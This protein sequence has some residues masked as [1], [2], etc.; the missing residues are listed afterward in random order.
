LKELRKA[1]LE[2]SAGFS[3]VK[4]V[5]VTTDAE[6]L[7]LYCAR[8]S[9]NQENTDT[10]LLRYLIR[11]KHWSPFELAHMV[12]EIRTS[13]AIAQQILRHRSFSFQEFSQR[14]AEAPGPIVYLGR[15]KG[16]TNRQ[17]SVDDLTDDEQTRWI[18]L[19]MDAYKAAAAAYKAALE[20]GIAN[21]C[22]RFVLPLAT[23]TKLYV[24]GS[25]RSWIHWIQLRTDEHT[26]F[27]HRELANCAKDIFCTQFP[28]TAEAL[29]WP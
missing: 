2:E 17:S 22:A 1:A 24:S 13:R 3:P 12:L 9:S 4:L 10:G 16:S 6:D 21:E 20:L 15:R 8:V 14:Y 29:E 18:H 27:E 19:Q 25:V 23:E 7:I 11:N 28:N 5:S 26:Q